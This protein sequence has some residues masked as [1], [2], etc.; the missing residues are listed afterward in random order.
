MATSTVMERGGGRVDEHG[1]LFEYTLKF[2]L[3]AT[4]LE[5]VLYRLIS[6]LGMHF[7]KLA[8]KYEAVRLFFKGVSSI[9]FTL[10]NVVA[11][12]VFLAIGLLLFEKAMGHGRKSLDALL[13]PAVGLLMVITIGFLIIP[14]A[15]L[16]AVAY[17][18][19]TLAVLAI[20][21]IEYLRTHENR[22]QRAMVITFSL[23]ILSWLYYQ[24]AS[25][26]A[27]LVGTP[28]VPPLVHEVNRAG[29]ACMV[30]ASIL[31][32]PAY[33][34]LSW[35]TKNHRQRRRFILLAA[36]WGA[37][38][39]A[40]L[41]LDVFLGLYD[42]KLAE[43]V[44]KGSE[45]IGWIFQMGMGYTFY[46]PFA[47]YVTGLICWAYTVVKVVAM[48]RLA[49]YG[50]GLMFMAGYALQLSHLT[51]LVVLGLLLLTMERRRQPATIFDTDEHPIAVS[52]GADAAVST[53][54]THHG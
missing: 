30:A 34:G 3:L 19:V 32:L 29:E 16:G 5:L 10:L 1:L 22:W 48:G 46:L 49:G 21:V 23:G 35:R 52:A 50:L 45:G 26:I 13:L 14:P 17:N 44:R 51:L 53:A 11:M 36:G 20:L 8:A 40:L 24:T 37:A 54:G 42:P 41:F 39:L 33:A 12:L 15:M 2:L 9:G 31:V 43:S 4:F 28:V 38:F 47:L 25:T 27:G 18:V 6:R 7:G